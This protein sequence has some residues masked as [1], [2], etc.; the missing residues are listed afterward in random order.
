MP[1]AMPE[2]PGVQLP[3]LPNAAMEAL[4][5]RSG[6]LVY[7]V[8]A[9]ERVRTVNR[10]LR[11]RID[12]ELKAGLDLRAFCRLLYPDPAARDQIV[13]AHR[14]ALAG[15]RVREAEWVLATR[16]GDLRQV[17]WQ[18]SHQ[19]E[20]KVLVMLGEDV[21][22]RRKLEHWVRLQNALLEKVPEAVIVADLDGRITT[23]T[24]GAEKVL[25]Y[26]PRSALERPLSNLFAGE[27]ARGV[28]LDWIAELRSRGALTATRELRTEKGDT[29]EC[30]VEAGR[31]VNERGVMTA[32]ML[33]AT[34]VPP[35]VAAAPE[36][37][38][39]SA[40]PDDE[41]AR[42][43][44]PVAAVAV[45]SAGT[46]GA[47]KTWSRGAERL[48]GM[49]AAKAT[50][51]VLFDEVMTCEGQ[52]WAAALGRLGSRGRLAARVVV[53][54]P[55]GTRA[56]ADLDLTAVKGP[57][58]AIVAVFAFLVDRS[59]V[60]GLA[61]QAL[62][63]KV[64]ALQSVFVDGLVRRVTDTC[65][66]FEPDHRVILARMADL[67]SLA[68]LHQG[69]AT[70]R[71]VDQAVRRMD[72][73]RLDRELDETMYGLGEGVAR[74]RALVADIVRF[75]AADADSPGHA[76]LSREL[77]A[78]RDLVG[79]AFDNVVQIEW[80][81]DDLPPVR[82]S[83]APLLRGLCLLLLASA[84]TCLGA[85]DARV[86]LEGRTQGGW[87]YVDIRDNGQGYPVDVLSRLHDLPYL[88]AQAGYAALFVGLAREA[89]RAAGGN[90]E[91][92][93]AAGTGARARLS[94]PA[95]ESAAALHPVERLRPRV[96][97]RTRI[98]LVEEDE[99]LRR[100]LERHLA[101]AHAVDAFP[102]I[103][104]AMAAAPRPRWS[105]SVLAFPRPESFGLRL[106]ARFSEALPELHRN[107][108]VVV[109]PGLRHAT[110]ERL[111]RDG[112]ILLTRP[113][114]LTTLSTL[115]ERLVPGEELAME[116]VE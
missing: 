8:D 58:G 83:R 22:D 19:A 107:T 31:V 4:L 15:G 100:A 52:S 113:V 13:E 104:E 98:L 62:D 12:Y 26:S 102:T 18:F 92:E 6:A 30:Q 54:R 103:A 28:V 89:I 97:G 3:E 55:N 69:G 81:V 114:D 9:D 72:L 115:L 45:V 106:M 91:L 59:D 70:Q 95:A 99:L 57:D 2:A 94:F 64:R 16:Q 78:A 23:W 38:A 7:V 82:A 74:L 77:E 47:V 33:V 63:T 96:I 10:M 111:A 60:A 68:H 20:S 53:T 42:A 93:T 50:G 11:D 25:G 24:G 75:S 65:A 27:N 76:R 109:P 32:M 5:D 108:V 101:E 73:G 14:A 17:R 21:S 40:S 43:L 29:V 36:I 110:R 105:A 86:V 90:L 87:I 112:H 67:R 88:A 37:A 116:A 41:L 51:K 39:T 71:E 66:L 56:P 61:E 35:P 46:D 34:P 1:V 84:E 49:G 48:G 80:V 85:E 79:H 44:L